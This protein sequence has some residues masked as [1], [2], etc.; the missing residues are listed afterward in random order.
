LQLRPGGVFEDNLLIDNRGAGFIAPMLAHPDLPSILRRNVCVDQN[1]GVGLGFEVIRAKNA[2]VEDNLVINKQPG[3]GRSPA[4]NVNIT[5]TR[6]FIAGDTT[7]PQQRNASLVLKNNI[8][9]KA[10]LASFY[11][12]HDT[13]VDASGNVFGDGAQFPGNVQPDALQEGAGW[14]RSAIFPDSAR[15]ISGYHQWIGGEAGVAAFLQ[16]AVKQERANWRSAYTALAANA[17]L[18][19]GFNIS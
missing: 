6:P 16:Q 10:G 4:L 19:E 17:W 9:W 8:L 2:I 11:L 13:K 12:F 14:S 18:R 7:L 5:T 15:T 3:A 1:S